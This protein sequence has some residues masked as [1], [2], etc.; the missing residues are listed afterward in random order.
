LAGTEFGL[1]VSVNGGRT[2]T[3]VRGNLPRV[4]IDDMLISPTNDVVLGTHGR[5]IIVL[6]DAALLE[7]SDLTV[8]GEEA[9]LFPPRTATQYYEMRNLPSPGAFKYSGPN[10]DYGALITYHLKTAP[11]KADSQVTIQI[12]DSAGQMVRELKGPD[13]PGYNRLAWDLRYPLTF[14]PSSQDEGWFG[15]PKGTFVLPGEYR[16][17]LIA[18]GHELISP[19]Q[20]RID[21]RSR[22]T[23]EALKA[24]FEASQRLAE[25]TKGFVDGAKAVE[26]LDKQMTAV[27]AAVKDRPNTPQALTGRIDEFGKKIDKLKGQFRAGF[28]GPKFRYLDLFGQLQASTSMPTEAQ[29]TTIQHLTT[30]LTENLNSLNAAISQDW[31]ALES[32]LRTNNINTSLLQPVAVPKPQ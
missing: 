11:A 1:F 13:R 2:W 32:E 5:S 17:K 29:L 7:G 19:L 27:K 18:R 20:V 6:D 24:R 28:N 3:L 14:E 4:R 8:L 22:T 31:P 30:D 9:H 23:A 10:P 12:L 16:V 25:L 21:P 26:G 15:P